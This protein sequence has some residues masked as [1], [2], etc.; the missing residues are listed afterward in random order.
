[1]TATLS[2]GNTFKEYSRPI[3]INAKTNRNRSQY[4]TTKLI[5]VTRLQTRKRSENIEPK[6]VAQLV[7]NPESKQY[8]FVKNGKPLCKSIYLNY[9]NFH[10][11][12]HLIFIH[13][14]GSQSENS[15]HLVIP[16]KPNKL[17]KSKDTGDSVSLTDRD[18]TVQMK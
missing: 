6:A 8:S 5:K 18:K 17:N 3:K 9:S 16:N 4:K 12:Y 11:I 2:T 1:M 10:N 14:L 7:N 15:N 13:T